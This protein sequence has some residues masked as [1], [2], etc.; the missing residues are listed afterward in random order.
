VKLRDM[1]NWGGVSG[2]KNVNEESINYDL[3]AYLLF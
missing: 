2:V 3:F 1:G